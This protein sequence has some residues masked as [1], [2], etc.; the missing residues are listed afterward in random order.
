MTLNLI[1]WNMQGGAQRDP[2]AKWSTGVKGLLTYREFGGPTTST[3]RPAD[4]ICL[5]ECTE[6]PASSGQ[7][8]R[9]VGFRHPKG[10]QVTVELYEWTLSGLEKAYVTFS[11]WGTSN[12][13]CSSAVI[14]RHNPLTLSETFCHL[15]W[16]AETKLWRPAVGVRMNIDEDDDVNVWAY[17]FHA[18]SPGGPDAKT[19][20]QGIAGTDTRGWVV[21]GDFNREPDTLEGVLPTGASICSTGCNTHSTTTGL[22]HEYDYAVTTGSPEDGRPIGGLNQLSDHVPVRLS[23]G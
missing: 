15:V 10:E 5:Q 9:S 13:R 20:L 4:V 23:I 19:V 8:L 7:P 3:K 18:I 17:S 12:S 2:V 14:T 11:K 6:V 1:S 16:G 21:A 22:R